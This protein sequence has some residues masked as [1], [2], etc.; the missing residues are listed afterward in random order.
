MTSEEMLS[1]PFLNRACDEHRRRHARC[2]MNCPGRLHLIKQYQKWKNSGASG[3]PPISL[4]RRGRKRKN[5]EPT[6]ESEKSDSS[7]PSESGP[8]AKRVRNKKVEVSS[9]EDESEEFNEDDREQDEE[10]SSPANEEEE[11]VVLPKLINPL[12][13]AISFRPLASRVPVY[14]QHIRLA[15]IQVEYINNEEEDI[16][17]ELSNFD[18]D[19]RLSKSELAEIDLQTD[20]SCFF[21]DE[22]QSPLAESPLSSPSPK[23]YH[24]YS[25]FTQNSDAMSQ[26]SEGKFTNN[27]FLLFSD[28][29]LRYFS[30]AKGSARVL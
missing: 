18:E 19:E 8:K 25:T 5:P 10:E 26:S 20:I 27:H 12:V 6:V 29:F 21:A 30:K 3:A 22:Y 17:N 2:P 7:A 4:R 15:P 24:T 14:Q 13:S 16:L 11:E 28:L 1:N 9:E 23:V